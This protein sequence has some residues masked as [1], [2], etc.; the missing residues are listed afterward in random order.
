MPLIV[1][2]EMIAKMKSGSVT[3]NLA[4]ESGENIET[5]VK[6]EKFI[7]ENGVTCLV[8]TILASQ[9]PTTSIIIYSSNISNFLLSMGSMPMK[10]KDY[11]YMMIYRKFLILSHYSFT[12]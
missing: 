5:T 9:L 10:V 11:H 12:K 4:V 2:K 8:Y 1:A 6:D 3:V 7:M